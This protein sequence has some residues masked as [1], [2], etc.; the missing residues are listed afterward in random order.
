[1]PPAP[2]PEHKASV[3]TAPRLA[4]PPKLDGDFAADEWPGKNQSLEREPSRDPGSGAPSFVKV[5]YDDANLYLALTVAVFEADKLRSGTAFGQDDGAEL[6][7]AGKT[8]D[9]KPAIFVLRGY[10]GGAVQSVTDGGAPAA[11]AARLGQ[12]VQFATKKFGKNHGGW[13]SEWSIPWTALGLKPAP[14]LKIACNLGVY[15]SEAGSW[16]CLEGTLAENWRVEQ[17]GWLQL[18]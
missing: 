8:S 18:K 3:L 6:C 16:R 15:R 5:A 7:L 10:A 14:G 9:G 17:A 12:T 2:K 4:S 13:R 1:M 11:D